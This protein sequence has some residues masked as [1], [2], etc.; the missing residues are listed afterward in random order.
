MTKTIKTTAMSILATLLMGASSMAFAHKVAIVDMQQIFTQLPQ[1]AAV[2]QALQ[3]EFAE[4]RQAVEKLQGDIRFEAEKFKRESATMSKAQQDTLKE[5]IQ[6]MQQDF[7]DQ[8][9]PL[10][11][12]MKL[13]QNQELAKVQ[14][15]V[16]QAIEQEA[17]AGKFDE[18]KRKDTIIYID[19]DKIPD[20]S[21]KVI[22]RVSKVK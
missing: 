8:A 1:M 16:M 3:T 4:R 14:A 11:Q 21:D 2:E 6:K 19:A 15:L 9:R 7:A 17:K 10:E 22:E 13:R 5:K 18:V 12:E 20:L